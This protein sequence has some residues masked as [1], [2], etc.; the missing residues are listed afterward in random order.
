M[1]RRSLRRQCA[2]LPCRVRDGELQVLL[3]TSRGSGRWVIPKG[4]AEGKVAPH[5]L[6]AREAYEEAGLVGRMEERPI[7]SYHYAKRLKSGRVAFCS[8]AVYR[9]EVEREL[10]DWP[11]RGEREKRWMPPAQAARLVAEAD[12]A[13]ILH[14]LAPAP[15]D[16]AAS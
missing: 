16:E 15:P 12:L 11:E 4:W 8:V 1:S 9:L 6:A 7:G 3:I 10:D 14:G 13:A 5:L 2:A